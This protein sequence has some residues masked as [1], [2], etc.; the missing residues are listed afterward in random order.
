MSLSLIGAQ[1]SCGGSRPSSDAP[2]PWAADIACR[3]PFS[4][5]RPQPQPSEGSHRSLSQSQG[6]IGSNTWRTRGLHCQ[7]TLTR[8]VPRPSPRLTHS[9]MPRPAIVQIP[10]AAAL[11]GSGSRPVL[12]NDLKKRGAPSVSHAVSDRLGSLRG[13]RG[14]IKG[15]VKT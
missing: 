13:S 11:P 12:K 5:I 6:P 3:R 15:A 4:C 7:D 8:R 1:C 10:I 9:V 2:S 14:P